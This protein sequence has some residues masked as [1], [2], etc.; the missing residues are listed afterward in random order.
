MKIIPAFFLVILL[1][2]GVS[3]V[4]GQ[5]SESPKSIR[6]D[7]LYEKSGG[8][9]IQMVN[10]NSINTPHLDFSPA[11]Y[12]D[13]IVFISSR[14]KG[15]YVDPKINERFFQIYYSRLDP[16]GIP[17]KAEAF[18]GELN[19]QLHEGPL[20][21]T[22][23]GDRV[24]FT[25][26]NQK[27]GVQQKDA[28]GRVRLKI[29]TAE[30]G[31]QGWENIRSL[32]FNADEYSSQHPSLSY[33]GQR[34][35]FSSDRQG[36]YGGFDLWYVDRSGNTWTEPVNLGPAINTEGNEVF[37]FIHYSGQLF[38]SSDGQED[39][40][41]GLDIYSV[42]TNLLPD[43]TPQILVAPFNSPDDDLGFILDESGQKGFFS[44]NRQGG[45]GK[46]DI[47]AFTSHYSLVGDTEELAVKVA[48][49]VMDAKTGL[50]VKDARVYLLPQDA[51]GGIPGEV[52]YE[53]EVRRTA[54]SPDTPLTLQLV[55]KKSLAL[56]EPDY[57]TDEQGLALSATMT[58]RPYLVLVEK[59]GYTLLEHAWR[60]PAAPGCYEL[61]L[62]LKAQTCFPIEGIVRNQKTGEPVANARVQIEGPGLKNPVSMQA[63]PQGLFSYCVPEIAQY[64]LSADKEGY[65]PG[66]GRVQATDDAINVAK[67][68]ELLLLP[69]NNTAPEKAPEPLKEGSV[70]VLEN[71][72]YDYDK[73]TLRPGSSSELDIV[74]DMMRKYPE[75][76]IELGAHTDCRGNDAYNLR[77]SE[78]RA[79]S[80]KN[81]LISRG[82][83]PNRIKAKGYGESNIRNH[84]KDGV[85]CT[86]TEHASN[87]R[88]E[89]RIT[90]LDQ[91][92][93]VRY[94]N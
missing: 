48:I 92:I 76:Q 4:S 33:D 7:V 36:G 54:E 57:K 79:E 35:Y 86:E 91:P 13:G 40:M 21:F 6:K 70:V 69:Y 26:N 68:V 27:K 8:Q 52:L 61:M 82:I 81:Y 9:G 90:R 2:T 28:S 71:L 45:I 10:V 60:S 42:N 15:G 47:Y 38:F 51:F 74:Y 30:R 83:T 18:S 80:A 46:D 34:L 23:S 1:L 20:C 56:D 88:T 53:M 16:N 39:G 64:A 58:D 63:G 24:F 25:S 50:P 31:T 14:K 43:A 87:R 72:Y 11:W 5:Q 75:M 29:Y 67:P 94:R 55:R 78:A 17:V 89:I 3:S 41:G 44:S 85:S 66:R 73:S 12:H 22:R 77:L 59:S 19:S 84:C 62:T 49:Q 65:I 93:D 32:P 37:P